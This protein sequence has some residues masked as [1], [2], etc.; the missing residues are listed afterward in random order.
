MPFYT[1]ICADCGTTEDVM[2]SVSQYKV[3][4]FCGKNCEVK[5]AA[6]P[7]I[8]IVWSNIETNSQ[9]GQRWETNAQKKAWFEKHPN[10]RPMEVGSQE[11]KTF[12]N[13]LRDQADQTAKKRGYRDVAHYRKSAKKR[14]AEQKAA[15][16]ESAGQKS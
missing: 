4:A 7:T 2:R 15:K 11:E 10:A 9:I 14:I 16:Q 13:N 1:Q 8:G 12:R 6:T 3:C 5:L